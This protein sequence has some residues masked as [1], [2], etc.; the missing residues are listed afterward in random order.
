M[1]QNRIPITYTT[2]YI[3]DESQKAKKL[4]VHVRS[5]LRMSTRIG[6]IEGK[7]KSSQQVHLH[8]L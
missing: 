6:I 3:V 1:K 5:Y 2:R 4:H 7:P 8:V